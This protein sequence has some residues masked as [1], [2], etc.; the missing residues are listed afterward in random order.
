[1]KSAMSSFSI[2]Q[3][4]ELI[5]K[6]LPE[7]LERF[8][9]LRELTRTEQASIEEATEY[10]ALKQQAAMAH[11]EA[12]RLEHLNFLASGDFS[13][14]E[15]I[16]AGKFKKK[17]VLAAVKTIFASESDAPGEVLLR[18][19]TEDGVLDLGTGRWPKVVGEAINKMTASA[20]VDCLT[21]EGKKFLSTSTVGQRGANAGKTL[22]P[23]LEA[24][25]KRTGLPFSDLQAALNL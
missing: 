19:S 20:F 2:E 17:D 23:N 10:L 21:E 1:M 18:V 12:S 22:Y 16:R 8:N 25:S 7:K 24:M 13:A 14:E 5:Q 9:Q 11:N 15:V 4:I 3:Y 6:F